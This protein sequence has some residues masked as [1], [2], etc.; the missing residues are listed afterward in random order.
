[1][2]SKNTRLARF[3]VPLKIWETTGK[4]SNAGVMENDL[5]SLLAADLEFEV[6]DDVLSNM[7][8]QITVLMA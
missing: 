2:L 6:S 1:M 7:P 5:E 4:T 3:W 8:Y